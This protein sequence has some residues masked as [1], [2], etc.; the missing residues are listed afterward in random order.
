MYIDVGLI[1]I[2]V[3][4][5]HILL[6]IYGIMTTDVLKFRFH[7]VTWVLFISLKWQ[8]CDDLTFT[9]LRASSAEINW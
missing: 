4:S 3:I 9:T 8:Y 7:I 5:E 6:I 2:A 1:I